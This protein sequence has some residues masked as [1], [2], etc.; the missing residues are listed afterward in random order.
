M[1]HLAL[2]LLFV[3]LSSL[4]TACSGK[5]AVRYSVTGT[6]KEVSVRYVNADGETSE[7]TVVNLPFEL[8]LETDNSFDFQIYATN[9]SGQGEIECEVFAN[10]QRLGDARGEIFAGCDGSFERRSNDLET[11]FRGYDDVIPEGYDAPAVRLPEG[12]NGM[13]LF[14]GDQKGAERRDF[15]VYD[16]SS[17]E[18]IQLTDGLGRSSSCPSLSPNGKQISFVYSGSVFDLFILNLENGVLT[19]LINDGK[20]SLED[21]CAD[22]S[23]DGSQIIFTAAKKISGDWIHQVYSAKTDGAGITQLTKN[24]NEGEDYRNPVWSPDGKKIAFISNIFGNDVYVMNG[25]GS[26]QTLFGDIEDLVKDFHW[27]PDGSEIVFACHEG[28]DNIGEGVCIMN[29]D[30]SGLI[31][32]EDESLEGIY[33]TAWSPDGTK[34]AFA[35]RKGDSTDIYIVNPDSTG[36]MQITHLQG[37]VPYWISWI[38]SMDLPSEPIPVSID[39]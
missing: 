34:I 30:G 22:W 13:I 6:A 20:D 26:E 11:R 16:L 28:L 1:K 35:A 27:S 39:Q 8:E 29:S 23:P 12:V 9:I 10:D 33:Y 36:L 15:Y 32:V 4:L 24:T 25:N 19:N 5:T 21:F 2:V 14:A 7:E 3:L 37:M 17:S 38:S 31:K 18:L